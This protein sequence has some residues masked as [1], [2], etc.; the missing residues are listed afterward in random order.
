MFDNIY[1]KIR[2]IGIALFLVGTIVSFFAGCSIMALDKTI[3]SWTFIGFGIMIGGGML[4]YAIACLIYGFGDL[5]AKTIKT[6][7]LL[8]SLANKND[9]DEYDKI[10]KD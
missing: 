4:S 9:E 3:G 6:N 10:C 2:V 7:K 5:I 1:R 8:E